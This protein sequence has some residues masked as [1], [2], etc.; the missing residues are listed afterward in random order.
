MDDRCHKERV[1]GHIGQLEQRFPKAAVAAS[2]AG[3]VLGAIGLGA[4]S[5]VAP[6]AEVALAGLPMVLAPGAICS[7]HRLLNSESQEEGGLC[8][9]IH[10]MRWSCCRKGEK[11][12]GCTFK[13]TC[14]LIWGNSPPCILIKH[15]DPNAAK[16][17]SEYEVFKKEHTLV[18]INMVVSA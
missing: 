8:V 6:G 1:L 11:S 18:D 13:C 14:G 9:K 7:T 3:S 2:V 12:T 16:A 10:D 5:S 4:A 15:P 17:M